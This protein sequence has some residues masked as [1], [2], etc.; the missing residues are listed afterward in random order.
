M[1]TVEIINGYTVTGKWKNGQRGM[2]ALATRGGKKYF[3]KKYTKFVLP[4][5]GSM[6]DAKTM[7]MKKRDFNDFV[8][9]RKRVISM[10]SPVAGSGGNIIIPCDN[11]VNGL[12]YY[13]ATEF[14][15][16][17]TPDE[18]LADFFAGL[19][20]EKCM[21]MMKT[22]AGALSAVHTAGVIHSDLKIKN[23]IVV[24]NSRSNFVAKLID[25]DSSYPADEKKYIGGDDVFCSPE[26]AKYAGS[27]DEEEQAELIKSITNKTDI[28]SLGVCFHYYLVQEYPTAVE[29]TPRLKRQKELKE[30]AGK[31][32]NFF[33]SQLL[34]EGCELKLSDKIK[35]VNIRAL[36]Y[37]MLS[38]DPEK[39]P[40]AMQVLQRLKQNEPTIETPWPEHHITLEKSKLSGAGIVGFKKLKD[41][42]AA[43]YEVTLS[44]GKKQ[45]YTVEEVVELGYAKAAF[46]PK[47][48]DDIWP[49][50]AIAF[51][52]ATLNARGFVSATK[53]T[54]GGKKG[55]KLYR[56]DGSGMF[57]TVEKL[58]GV[59]YA[60]RTSGAV[61]P[62]PEPPTPPTPPVPPAPP[63]PPMPSEAEAGGVSDVEKWPEHSIEFDSEM[64]AKKGY[65][66]VEMGEKNGIKGY[67]FTRADGIRQFIRVEMVIMQKMARKV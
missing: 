56:K 35:S 38:M 48:F 46:V 58:L 11:F 1:E 17:V 15:D 9:I 45:I 30:R 16:G 62:A 12:H 3:L 23:I 49:E 39:R 32:V 67:Y 55:Y 7:E 29:L 43:K 20:D 50:H 65:V 18:E 42:G 54:L 37:D 57:Y 6:F 52:E 2:T 34:L 44:S 22:A 10:I 28:F 59:R 19:D 36:I 53:E 14:I 26:L 64:I 4:S 21:L 63:I 66:K 8:R 60:R 51:D 41:G 47:G 13:E 27:E 24:K 5:D 25:F 40:T 31:P 33:A 61:P